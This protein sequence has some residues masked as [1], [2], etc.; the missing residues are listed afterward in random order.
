MNSLP[1]VVSLL[2]DNMYWQYILITNKKDHYTLYGEKLNG[3]LGV[4]IKNIKGTIVGRFGSSFGVVGS[5]KWVEK[6]ANYLDKVRK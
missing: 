1:R 6:V 5:R 2:K 4:T 3:R